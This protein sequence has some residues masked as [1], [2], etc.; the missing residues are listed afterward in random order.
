[1]TGITITTSI[2]GIP[3]VEISVDDE[4]WGRFPNLDV[5]IDTACDY[6]KAP[7]EIKSQ[8]EAIGAMEAA[9]VL[10]ALVTHHTMS[11]M[12]SDTLQRCIGQR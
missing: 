4:V 5:A 3:V 6:I 12:Q 8:G 10:S 9:S 2:R 7:H 1:M 11:G